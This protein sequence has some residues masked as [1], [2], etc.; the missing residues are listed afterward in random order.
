MKTFVA[1]RDQADLSLLPFPQN[2]LTTPCSIGMLQ[3]RTG[4]T[5]MGWLTHA[6]ARYADLTLDPAP[7]AVF[8][9]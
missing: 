7:R 6:P 4:L 1:G 9:D 3:R 2:S 5:R 8:R